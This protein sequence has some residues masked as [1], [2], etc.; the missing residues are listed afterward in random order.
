VSEHPWYK[1]LIYYL[2]NQR[3]PDKLDTHQRRRI[4]LESA[5]YVII[6]DFLFQRSSD[7]VLLRYVNNEDTQKLLQGTHGYSYSVIHVGGH[8]LLKPLL[9]RLLENDTIGIHSFLTLMFSPN[10]V[11][12]AKNLLGKNSFQQCHCNLS[13]H[14]FPFQSGDW[15]LLVL[16]ILHLQQDFFLFW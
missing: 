13:S 4:C 1:N 3:C 15:I 2:Q 6:G 11:T 8:F 5:R 12:S 7:G 14:N 16:L 9:S 10:L